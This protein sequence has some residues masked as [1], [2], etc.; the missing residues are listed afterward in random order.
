VSLPRGEFD[1]GLTPGSDFP[2]FDTDFGKVGMMICWDSQFPEA[3]RRLA[4]GGAEI[5]MLPIWGGSE[6]LFVARAIE[7]QVFLVTS[8]F[9]AKSGIWNKRGELIAEAADE[10]SVALSEVDLSEVVFWD[11]IGDLRSHIPRESP[12]VKEVGP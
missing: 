10:G 7:N 5:I 2:V 12:P 1:S 4:A 6:P 8:S 3:A 9:D 11:W